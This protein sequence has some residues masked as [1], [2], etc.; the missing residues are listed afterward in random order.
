M[1]APSN[2]GVCRDKA[3]RGTGSVRSRFWC[4]ARRRLGVMVERIVLTDGDLSIEA[5]HGHAGLCH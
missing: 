1:P 3:A 5:W 2:D 4:R